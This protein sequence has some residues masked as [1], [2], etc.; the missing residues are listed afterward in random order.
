MPTEGT[1]HPARVTCKGRREGGREGGKREEEV[2][3]FFA[4]S[5]PSAQ[6][7]SP[8]MLLAHECREGTDRRLFFPS[9]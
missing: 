8:P 6:P 7:L 9:P 4:L 3:F 5:P 1:K 2:P